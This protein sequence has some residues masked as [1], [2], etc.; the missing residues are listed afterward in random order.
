MR[1]TQGFS[2][3][4]LLMSMAFLAACATKPAK[5]KNFISPEASKVP[6]NTISINYALRH[7]SYLFEL[8]SVGDAEFSAKS[9][10]N[11]KVIEKRKISRDN[12][13]SFANRIYD[14]AEKYKAGPVVGEECKTPFSIRLVKDGEI[15][16]V[17]GC[18]T[19][20]GGGELGKIIREGEILFYSE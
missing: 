8:Q 20:D 4:P 6:S 13:I 19:Q 10:V 7:N 16:E 5:E 11:E 14:F 2:K 3:Y 1:K 12:Y 9:V 18:R 17:Q 15:S